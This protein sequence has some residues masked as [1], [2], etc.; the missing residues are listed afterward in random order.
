MKLYRSDTLFEFGKYE[1]KTVWQ[2]LDL[3]INYIDWCIINI[4]SFYLTV[5]MIDAIKNRN[6]D[7]KLSAEGE[8]K[9]KEKDARWKMEQE[10]NPDDLDDEIIEFWH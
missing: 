3:Q 10:S 9:L 8:Q 6:P 2:V 4:N 7:F 5:Y 1:G